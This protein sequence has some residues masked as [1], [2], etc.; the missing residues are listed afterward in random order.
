MT[1]D[2]RLYRSRDALIGGVCAGM[3]EYFDIDPVVVRILAVVLTIAS[4]GAFAIAYVALW[5]LLPL[6]PDPSEPVDVQPESVHSETY[7]PIDYDAAKAK[8]QPADAPYTAPFAS[9]GSAPYGPYVGVS[10]P[11]PGAGHVPP[12]PPRTYAD[13]RQNP[14]SSTVPPAA[15]TPYSSQPE[16]A[17]QAPH[18]SQVPPVASA[19]G[20]PEQPVEPV[21]KKSVRVALWFGF[22]CL[23]IGFAAILSQ[24]I[25]GVV[26]WQFWPLMLIIAGIG[27]VVIPAQRGK[28]MG[29]FVSGLMIISI[30]VV[31]LLMSLRV[32]EYASFVPML[33]NLWP[34][35]IMMVGFFIISSAVKNPVFELF[36]GMC[37]VAFCVMGLLW[38]TVSGPTEFMTILIPFKDAVTISINPWI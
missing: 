2:R 1:S 23:F 3:A 5:I 4:A 15:Q 35:L 36:G 20:M 14:A 7:G 12:E 16:Y 6:S 8:D 30:G 34:L 27:D 26:W 9:S 28:R 33:K 31:L 10:A 13:A 32:I 21:S 37:F 18:V 19:A 38:F 29:Q 24:F 22:L 11:Y 25:E 17:A